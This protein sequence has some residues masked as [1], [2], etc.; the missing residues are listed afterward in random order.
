MNLTQRRYELTFN[1]LGYP[2]KYNKTNYF[3]IIESIKGR[4]NQFTTSPK[5]YI[6]KSSN[7][8][9]YK[10]SFIIKANNKLR[11]KIETLQSKPVLPKINTEYI[12]IEKRI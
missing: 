12:E 4:K 2:Q 8:E 10:D 11:L 5:K 1:L 7:R 6:I 3:S 9:P